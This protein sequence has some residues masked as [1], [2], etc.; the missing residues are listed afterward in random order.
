MHPHY[1]N[2]IT[3]ATS[4]VTTATRGLRSSLRGKCNGSLS[5]GTGELCT[6]G[7]ELVGFSTETTEA[8]D[9][10]VGGTVPYEIPGSDVFVN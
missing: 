7:S 2:P 5:D 10:S 4:E 8:P 9:Y 3:A 1:L 6:G